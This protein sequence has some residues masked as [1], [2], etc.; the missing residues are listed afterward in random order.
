MTAQNPA[1]FLQGYAG[2]HPAEDTRRQIGAG[3][4]NRPGIVGPG[5][6]AVTQNGTP[7]MSVNVAGGQAYIAGSE[8]TYQGL[9]FV[10]NRGTTNL[11]IAAADATNARKDLIVAKV[12]DAQY[13]GATNLWSLAVVTG[14][15]AAVPAEPAAPANSLVLAVVNVAALAT[16]I[17]NANITDRR[18]TPGL[19]TGNLGGRAAALGAPIPCTSTTRPTTGLVA[20]QRIV[21]TD[22][23]REYMWSG[24]AW[25]TATTAIVCTS[26]T[27]PTSPLYEGLEIYETDTDRQYVYT[28]TSWQFVRH[29]SATGR[30]GAIL[31]GATQTV[32]TG[33]ATDITWNT[34]V[35]DVDGW[36]AAPGTTLTTPAGW[37]GRYYIFCNGSWSAAAGTSQHIVIDVN[38]SARAE[39]MV[40]GTFSRPAA[41][42]AITLAAGD[43]IKCRVFHNAGANRDFT[44]R[45]EIM[46]LGV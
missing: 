8:A 3:M 44:P 28:G 12:Q 45:L 2:G 7:N 1:I 35:S 30:P 29:Y 27:R 24:S 46:Y 11:T 42:L 26:S 10:E 43:T 31:T 5:D 14:T 13:S 6:L 18:T 32:V 36:I 19:Y 22:T 9:Y 34:E 39:G 38:G 41:S 4:A 37:G 20:G 25:L 16:S 17:T 40:D 21:E 15:P 23:L 33:T